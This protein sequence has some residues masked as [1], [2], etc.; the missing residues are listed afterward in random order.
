M[1]GVRSHS[2]LKQ[3]I[4]FG[5]RR[6]HVHADEV[7]RRE[8]ELEHLAKLVFALLRAHGL[9]HLECSK[10]NNVVVGLIY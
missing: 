9:H 6:L 1:S 4:D 5:A 8:G 7:G 10:F 3:S 2:L